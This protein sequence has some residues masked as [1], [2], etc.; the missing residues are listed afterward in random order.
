MVHCKSGDFFRIVKGAPPVITPGIDLA[1]ADMTVVLGDSRMLNR[2]V[3]RA[4]GSAEEPM[5]DPQRETKFAD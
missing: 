3:E 5:T 2:R 1:R 4:I